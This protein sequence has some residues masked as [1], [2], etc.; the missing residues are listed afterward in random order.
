MAKTATASTREPYPLARGQRLNVAAHHPKGRNVA[1]D[2]DCRQREGAGDR[3][4]EA[5]AP[6][7]C[8]RLPELDRQRSREPSERAWHHR[9][10][11]NPRGDADDAAEEPEQDG[12][13]DVE[14]EN[15]A[16]TEAETLQ[17]GD[18]I[19]PSREPRAHRLRDANPA[20]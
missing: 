7:K 3:D 9:Q 20:D 1:G 17:H 4:S 6:Q 11:R 12:L 15:V 14:R 19:E 10:N 18:R 2:K 13:P 8:R 5:D 16:R